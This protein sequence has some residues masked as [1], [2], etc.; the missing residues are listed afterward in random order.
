MLYIVLTTGQCNLRCRYCG[1]SFPPTQV[2]WKIQYPTDHL[3]KFIADDPDPIIAFY[4]GEPL[5][6]TKLIRETM[7][8]P[9]K[10]VIQTNGTLAQ[11]LE[12]EYWRRFDTVLL[13]IDGEKQTTDHYRGTG[14]HDK[15]IDAA[16]W[17]RAI[18]F[19]N[20]L[21]AR[22]AVSERS[23][24]FSDVKHLLDLNLFD[25]IHW[26]LDAIWSTN[27]KNFNQWCTASYMPGLNRL[28]RFWLEEARKGRVLGLVPFVAVLNAMI[29][30]DKI[31]CPPCEAGVNSLAVLTSGEVLACPIAFDAKWARLGSIS[32]GVVAQMLG[33]VR[34]GEPCVACGY[35]RYCG[36]RCLY[37]HHE[38]FWGEEGFSKVCELTIRML[39]EL[40]SIKDETSNL[41]ANKTISAAQLNYP[42]FNNTTEIIP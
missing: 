34:I 8:W 28:I 32:N 6:N 15:V 14:I 4:G 2:P 37:A 29:K 35:V 17:L 13:S 24:I 31:S 3:R 18:G 16:K 41:L 38:R 5:L 22:M 40:A 33:K 11:K 20:D 19:K 7:K 26:Q 12:P 27:W 1:G 9:A 42:P 23:D 39:T 36:G 10:F 21:I 30:G 25:H